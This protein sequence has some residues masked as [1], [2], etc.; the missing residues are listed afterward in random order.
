MK[1]THPG[2]EDKSQDH[3][4][5]H[6]KTHSN[7]SRE[8]VHI[9]PQSVRRYDNNSQNYTSDVDGCCYVLGVIK[10]LY[11]DFAGAEG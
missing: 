5:P 6:Q 9:V 3:G 7:Q 4:G 10:A 2:Y 11:F 1:C 8:G